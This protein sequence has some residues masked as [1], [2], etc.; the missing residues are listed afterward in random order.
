M[1]ILYVE[2]IPD[3]DCLFSAG[4]AIPVPDVIKLTR[5]ASSGLQSRPETGCFSPRMTARRKESRYRQLVFGTSNARITTELVVLA[6]DVPITIWPFLEP[7]RRAVILGLKQLSEVFWLVMLMSVL[8]LLVV[9]VVM[10]LA[11][12]YDR[13]NDAMV[14]ALPLLCELSAI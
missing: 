11:T 1:N 2:D 6:L 12:M 3:L 9:V 8:I 14:V 4:S 10:S 13:L 5:V 7:F